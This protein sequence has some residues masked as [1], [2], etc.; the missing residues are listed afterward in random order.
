MNDPYRFYTDLHRN[1]L[2]K[3]Y[4]CYMCSQWQKVD[5]ETTLEA[6]GSNPLCYSCR[7]DPYVTLSVLCSNCEEAWELSKPTRRSDLGSYSC[8]NCG[9]PAGSSLFDSQTSEE[10]EVPQVPQVPETPEVTQPRTAVH[11]QPDYQ[12]IGEMLDDLGQHLNVLVFAHRGEVWTGSDVEG[13]LMRLVA[14]LSEAYEVVK[15][16]RDLTEIWTTPDR[17]GNPHPEGFRVEL[18]DALIG[19]ASMLILHGGAVEPLVAK[20]EYREV[21]GW[22]KS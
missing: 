17:N 2:V 10:S 3:E 6:I 9:T 13:T 14:E 7:A 16:G 12:E 21:Y 8:P 1:D 11:P 20:M 5:H 4:R 22:G 18:I 15:S 19:I